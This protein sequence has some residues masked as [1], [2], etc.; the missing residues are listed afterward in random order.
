[1]EYGKYGKRRVLKGLVWVK[2][3]FMNEI[4]DRGGGVWLKER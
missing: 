4:E 3:V 1:M 2:V